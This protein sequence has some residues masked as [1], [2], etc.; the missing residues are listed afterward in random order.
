MTW[1][2]VNKLSMDIP[3]L[4]EKSLRRTL[5]KNPLGGNINSS[6]N[7]RISIRA[8]DD[9][10]FQLTSGDRLAIL[11]HN[12]AGKTSLLRALAGIYKPRIGTIEYS[13]K[14]IPLFNMSLGIEPDLSGYENIFIISTFM[15]M[16]RKEIEQKIDEIIKFTDLGDF[17]Y[18]PVKTYSAGMLTR[19]SFAVATSTEPNILLLDEQIGAGDSNFTHKVEQR[20]EGFYSSID[21]IIL[22][23]H[24]NQLLKKICTKGMILE[25]GKIISYGEIDTIVEQYESN[26]FQEQKIAAV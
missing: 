23:S 3:I 6:N 20:L 10:S 1:L 9:L 5:V 17:I 22:A 19:L 16:A 7:Q 11:G 2:K 21:I 15:G 26:S 14:L 12:G 13:G 8:L 25:K 24:S 4:G 18:L